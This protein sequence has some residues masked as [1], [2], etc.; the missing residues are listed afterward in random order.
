M[1]RKFTRRDFLKLA[2]AGAAV[3]AALGYG[4][5][6]ES[7]GDPIIDRDPYVFNQH[8]QTPNGSVPILIINEQRCRKSFWRL[9]R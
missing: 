4:V 1:K 6:Q 3:T 9:S 7:N 2:G 5:Y 8:T